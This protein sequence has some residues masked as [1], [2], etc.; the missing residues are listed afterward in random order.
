VFLNWLRQFTPPL[1]YGVCVIINMRYK[2]E[3]QREIST[4][5]D[6]ILT[7]SFSSL[8]DGQKKR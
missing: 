2:P 8:N 7:G 3:M 4:G 5:R 1:G 6:N